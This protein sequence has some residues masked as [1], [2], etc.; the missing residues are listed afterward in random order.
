MQ[1]LHRWL[2]DWTQRQWKAVRTRSRSI[3]LNNR[4]HQTTQN[5]NAGLTCRIGTIHGITK[6]TRTTTALLFRS[7]SFYWNRKITAT[8]VSTAHLFS[9]RLP[10]SRNPRCFII[11]DKNSST[12]HVIKCHGSENSESNAVVSRILTPYRGKYLKPRPFHYD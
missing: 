6:L 11:Y 8:H 10:D 5:Q 12:T 7:I 3:P 2:S 1:N 4:W 9:K